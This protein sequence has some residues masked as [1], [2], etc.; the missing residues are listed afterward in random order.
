MKNQDTSLYKNSPRNRH[1]QERQEQPCYQS[2]AEP[3]RV[4]FHRPGKNPRLCSPGNGDRGHEHK[5]PDQ[6]P[7]CI[8]I[9]R[10]DIL[11]DI[12]N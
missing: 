4:I 12:N 8:C 3:R 1:K 9:R 10:C 11:Y 2:V 5:L 7:E 6:L